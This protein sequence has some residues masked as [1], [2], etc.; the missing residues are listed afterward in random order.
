MDLL[1]DRPAPEGVVLD[2]AAVA[3]LRAAAP[4]TPL[5]RALDLAD[6][7]APVMAAARAVAVALQEL[8]QRADAGRVTS[9]DLDDLGADLIAAAATI[10]GF[11]LQVGGLQ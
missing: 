9:A 1:T 2:A 5:E 7:S 4:S 3:A 10:Q 8:A 11:A 6:A